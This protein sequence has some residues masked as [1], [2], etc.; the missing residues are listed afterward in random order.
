M[1]KTDSRQPSSSSRPLVLTMQT[2]ISGDRAVRVERH[3]SH[4]ARSCGSRSSTPPPTRRRTTTRS[5]PRSRARR[6]RRR[7]GDEPLSARPGPARG[8]ATAGPSAST[9]WAGESAVVKAAQHPFDMLRLARR[10]RR[11]ARRRRALP[12]AAAPE[13]DLRLLM[14]AFPRPRVLTA[15]DCC[16]ARGRRAA[17]GPLAALLDAVDA[18]RRPLGAAGEQR[19]VGELG[20]SP[21]RVRVIPHGAFDYLD[22]LPA[23]RADRPGCRR[24]RRP[25][26]GA[27]LRADAPLQGDRRAD[28]GV[29]RHPG[30]CRAAGRRQGDDAARAAAP[31][32]A[33]AR[34]LR[35]CPLRP[36]LHHRP[37]DPGL[38]SP[39]RPRR[40]ALPRDR[41]VGRALHRARLRLAA[42]A[43]RGGR[44][45]RGRRA[46]WRGTPGRR[47]ATPARSAD[48][49]AELLD[50]EPA[51]P[52]ALA[53]RRAEPPSGPYSWRARG[54]ADRASSTNARWSEGATHD[55]ARA[56]SS[57][58]R[59]A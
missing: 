46:A 57:G 20:V 55:L 7:A 49:L 18:R 35:S 33:R 54:G 28:R 51:A 17:G 41:A 13:L 21:Q 34:H 9:A 8:R 22:A 29:R 50:D 59:S 4:N 31:P 12:V 38:L 43:E 6:P 24:P 44:L 10:L 15:H 1:A 11:E 32:R 39:R 53:T 56:G 2:E 26:G 19:L 14:R 48:A 37:R 23:E 30:R 25:Q 42:G 52:S 47:P 45:H 3:C 27:Q 58:S 36:A 5:A 16:R 40:A